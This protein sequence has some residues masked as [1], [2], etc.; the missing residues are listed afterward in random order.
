MT[1]GWDDMALVG[2][3]ARAHG[4]RGQVIVN[5]ETDFPGGAVPARRPSC[6]STGCGVVEGR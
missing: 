6:S 4:I 1:A 3:I 5:P 2:R